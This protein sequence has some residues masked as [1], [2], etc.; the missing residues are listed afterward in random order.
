MNTVH[1]AFELAATGKYGSVRH[2]RIKLQKEHHESV[3]AHLAG[4][5]IKRQ[6]TTIIQRAKVGS[7]V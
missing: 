2:L 6:L 1:R 5:V 3:E 4:G 7:M